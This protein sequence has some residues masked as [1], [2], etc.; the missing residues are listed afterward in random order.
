MRRV[1]FA[2]LLAFVPLAF[3]ATDVSGKW[4]GSMDLKLPDG[5]VNSTPVVADLKQAGNTVT[6]TAGAVGHEGLT[7]EKGVIDGGQLTFEVQTGEGSYA[8]KAKVSDSQI[9]GEVVFITG[10]AKQTA[11]LVMTR[12]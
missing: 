9:K 7:I 11:T 4:T 10:G 3:A 12:N 5:S 1:L 2:L 8:V 6:G